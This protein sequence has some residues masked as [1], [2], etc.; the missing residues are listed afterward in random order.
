MTQL[1]G[2]KQKQPKIT[3]ERLCILR[4][5]AAHP[6]QVVPYECKRT[7][8]YLER[9]KLIQFDNHVGW[10]ITDDGIHQL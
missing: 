5:I 7:L 2:L 9:W 3:G 4:W 1:I 6:N 8:G 10:T